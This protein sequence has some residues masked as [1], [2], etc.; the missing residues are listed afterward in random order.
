[1]ANGEAAGLSAAGSQKPLLPGLL[2]GTVDAH[3]AREHGL[4][5]AV[6][7]V[8]NRTLVDQ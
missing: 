1:M 2:G 4:A 8:E 6:T 5:M 7:T 3:L